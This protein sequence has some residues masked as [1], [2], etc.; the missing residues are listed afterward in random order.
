M[1]N[2]FIELVYRVGFIIMIA[3]IFSQ[4]TIT[5]KFLKYENQTLY[6]KIFIGLFLH[7]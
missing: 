5:K 2:I 3:F 7:C 4:V 1:L 6:N